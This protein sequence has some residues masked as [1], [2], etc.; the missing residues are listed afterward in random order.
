VKNGHEI[1]LSYVIFV[2]ASGHHNGG[3]GVLRLEAV[4]D[5]PEASPVGVVFAILRPSDDYVH[6]PFWG[7][8]I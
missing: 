2:P 3:I 8:T 6:H 4:H 7:T 1:N 5:V